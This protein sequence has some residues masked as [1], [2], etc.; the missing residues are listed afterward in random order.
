M[1]EAKADSPNFPDIY[2]PEALD[3]LLT[4]RLSLLD[5]L[6]RKN[7]DMQWTI[8]LYTVWPEGLAAL[9]QAG[10]KP[11]KSSL[12][13]ACEADCA[14]SIEL[15]TLNPHSHLGNDVMNAVKCLKNSHVVELVVHALVDRRRTLQSLA[16]T[17]LPSDVVAQLHLNPNS[18]LG[19]YAAKAYQ[20]LKASGVIP[21]ASEEEGGWLVYHSIGFNYDMANQLWDAGFLDVDEMD[22][23]GFTSFMKLDDWIG[24]EDEADDLKGLFEMAA[25]LISKGADIDCKRSS[26]P[27]L[28]YF[29][30]ALGQGAHNLPDGVELGWFQASETCLG[31]TK[32]VLLYNSRDACCFSCS[33]NGCCAVTRMM[34]GLLH[35][36]GGFSTWGFEFCIERLSILLTPECEKIFAEQAL[37]VL[38]FLT[39]QAL[40]IIHTCDHSG[41]N[42]PDE[43]RQLQSEQEDMLMELEQLLLEFSFVHNALDVSFLDFLG[44]YWLERMEEVL[45]KDQLP[46]QEQISQM[47]KMGVIV[48]GVESLASG[49]FIIGK[50]K[51]AI[52]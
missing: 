34:A 15:L 28:H 11:G 27:A 40:E 3:P 8:D 23:Q 20:L 9:L 39:F 22:D 32:R 26:S 4:R 33:M 17:H 43:I 21:D 45:R 12:L 48:H 51:E 44:G 41:N 24:Y 30:Y 46:N 5:S 49:V 35:S 13:K 14:K 7:V 36:Q 10:Y 31:L 47:R 6:L 19:F 16:M 50:G 42:D 1:K 2:L 18:P 29:G 37:A 52:R 25:W 38:R